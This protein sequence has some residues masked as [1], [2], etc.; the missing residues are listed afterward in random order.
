MRGTR[1]TAVAVLFAGLMGAPACDRDRD[2]VVEGAAGEEG[3]V[4]GLSPEQIRAQAEEMSPEQA[5]QLGIVDTTI[6]MENL[7][8]PD[9]LVELT[10]TAHI[11]R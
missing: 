11:I 7:A 9:S 3:A 5:E 4:E 2:V 6:H 1:R 8:N 10:D